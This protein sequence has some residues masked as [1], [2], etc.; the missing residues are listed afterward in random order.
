MQSLNLF[1]LKKLSALIVALFMLASCATQDQGP[2]SPTPTEMIAIATLPPL[3]PVPTLAALAPTSAPTVFRAMTVN[4][5]GLLPYV[6]ESPGQMSRIVRVPSAET[7][8]LLV[9]RTQDNAWVEIRFD[10]GQAGW[11][12]TGR[13]NITEDISSLPVTGLTANVDF[14]AVVPSGTTLTIYEDTSTESGAIGDVSALTPVRITGRRNENDWLRIAT[15][16]QQQGWVQANQLDLSTAPLEGIAVIL[17]VQAVE[18]VDYEVMARVSSSSGG[19]RLR[20]LPNTTS[21]VLFNLLAGTELQLNGRTVDQQWVLVETREGYLGWVSTSFL[22]L[23]I[24]VA[25]VAAIENPEPAPYVELAPPENAPSVVVSVGG[26]ARSIFMQGQAMGNQRNVFTTVGDSLT[27]TNNFL[28]PLMT[29]Y[30]LGE[31]GYLLPVIQFFSAGSNSYRNSSMSARASWS[32]FSA[33]DPANANP[34]VCQP[35]ETPIQCEFRVTRPAVAIIM[36]GTNDAPAFPASTYE[37]NMR[38]II[39]TAINS[40]VVPIL[41]TLPPRAQHNDAIIAYNQVLTNLSASYGIPLT[42][43]YSS[44]VNKP[45]RG[46]DADGVHLSTPS[47]APATTVDFTGNNMDYGTTMRNLT[48]L[49][50]LDSVWRQ[51]LY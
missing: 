15:A 48:V 12:E 32:T 24:D 33:L 49:Q 18:S 17:D 40:G 2:P 26:G 39:E 41:S 51:V 1:N 31:Y 35:G 4:P 14:V 44:L 45:N 42:D 29:S 46:L 37:A 43:L 34:G 38:R 16:D 50:I 7:S 11:V 47:G 20:R 8:V 25:I 28:R 19:L 22:E 5:L 13:V 3:T 27:D 30:N 23:E 36:I 6:H 21:T 9:G 10:D